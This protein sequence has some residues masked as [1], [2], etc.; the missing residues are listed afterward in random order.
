[1]KCGISELCNK[2]V[3]NICDGRRLGCV[4]DA[5]VDVSCGKIISIIVPGE[6]K[7][8]SLTK[9]NCLVIP[10]DCITRFGDDVILVNCTDVICK[11]DEHKPKKR[12]IFC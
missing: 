1:M 4:C 12:N 2:E 9:E 6:Q 11:K 10:W 5:E 3:I 8:F 7:L